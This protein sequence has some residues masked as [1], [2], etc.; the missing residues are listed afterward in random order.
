M[1]YSDCRS[2]H[3]KQENSRK[4]GGG[5][6]RQP[7]YMVLGTPFDFFSSNCLKRSPFYFVLRQMHRF[8][9]L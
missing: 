3:H 1:K 5:E 6:V 8:H 9:V 4:G 2:V 7:G